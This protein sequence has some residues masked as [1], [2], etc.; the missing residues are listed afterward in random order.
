MNREKQIRLLALFLALMVA[1]ASTV[2]VLGIQV[3]FN[4]GEKSAKIS[5]PFIVIGLIA[6]L[7]VYKFVRKQNRTSLI[8]ATKSN[9]QFSPYL[10]ILFTYLDY[11][12]WCGILSALCGAIS[13]ILTSCYTRFRFETLTNWGYTMSRMAIVFAIYVLCLLIYSVGSMIAFSQRKVVGGE[14]NG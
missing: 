5:A 11:M 4:Q 7:V 6:V 10:T 8:I 13:G 14:E 3:N 9:K 1:I 12:I 2:M